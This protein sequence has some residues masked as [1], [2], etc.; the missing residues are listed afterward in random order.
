[1]LSFQQIQ[2]IVQKI[3]TFYQ[4]EKVLLFGSYANG[5]ANEDSDLD[6]LVVKDT[7]LPNDKRAIEIRNYLKGSMIPMD[8]V[9]YTPKELAD[10]QNVK[11]TFLHEILKTSK[12]LY[13]YK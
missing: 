7:D 1:M 8:I 3:I 9:V 11:Y 10:N 13:E 12:V 4:P 5:N 2:T 6:L